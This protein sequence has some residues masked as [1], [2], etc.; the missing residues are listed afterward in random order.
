MSKI[1]PARLRKYHAQYLAELRARPPVAPL[2]EA[3]Q[4]ERNIWPDVWRS[5][6]ESALCIACASLVLAAIVALVELP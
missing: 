2:R 6:F 4:G 3:A 5:L 1:D